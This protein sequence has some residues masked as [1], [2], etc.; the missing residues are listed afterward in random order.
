MGNQLLK[1]FEIQKD[2]YL[3]GGIRQFWKVHSA[4]HFDEKD[5]SVYSAFIFKKK[6]LKGKN[7]PNPIK[8]EVFAILK[9]EPQ[10][11]AK[12]KHPSILSVAEP[13]IEHSKC[14]VFATERVLNSLQGLIKAGGFA[15]IYRSEVEFKLH[16]KELIDGVSFLHNNAKMAHLNICP[17]NIYVTEQNKWKISGLNFANFVDNKEKSVFKENDA[18][19]KEFPAIFQ[20]NPSY[21]APEIFDGSNKM[22][23]CSD[24]FS[25]GMLILT[26]LS[27]LEEKTSK[28]GLF[29]CSSI[30]KHK[31]ELT[32]FIAQ[33]ETF[34]FFQKL[35]PNLKFILSRMLN[36][37]PNSRPII[38]EVGACQWL[39]DPL[40]QTLNYL[41]SLNQRDETQQTA[42]FKG[43]VKIIGKFEH[44]IIKKKILPRIIE[45]IQK[46]H[47]S[48]AVLQI[49][50]AALEINGF[51]ENKDEFTSV[52]WPGI[53]SLT[54]MKEISAQSLF[55]LVNG[56]PKLS[57]YLTNADLQSSLLPLLLKCYD[58]G[59]GKLEEAILKNTEYLVKKLEFSLIKNRVLPKVLKLSADEKHETRKGAIVALSKI[60]TIFDKTTV[61]EQIMPTLE[62]TLKKSNDPELTF[63][64]LNMYDGMSKIIGIEVIFLK[65]ILYIYR[66]I[67]LYF[68]P[69]FDFLFH[70]SNN[71]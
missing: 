13:L 23:I 59:V 38:Q 34:P 54:A 44:K 61:N 68:L 22:S 4:S 41:D 42:F 29:N 20:P 12:L 55:L 27:N 24:I 26:I 15:E 48:S 16:L 25:L 1:T 50:L 5:K 60:C 19:L 30:S 3:E 2:S 64:V 28:E 63:A 32:N 36:L 66:N 11:L 65:K 47:C 40:V 71:M 51:V 49:I 21:S 46:D 35:H 53:K 18:I 69:I 57:E 33:L 62:K 7:I 52:L 37:N 14:L 43:L 45:F 67:F 10:N 31:D 6:V 70:N 56:L 8:D 17:E 39:N 9:K 58:C